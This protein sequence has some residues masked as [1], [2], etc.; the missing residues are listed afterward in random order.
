MVTQSF[1]DYLDTG[2]PDP[3]NASINPRPGRALVDHQGERLVRFSQTM[4]QSAVWHAP[5]IS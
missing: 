4:P 3:V 5:D 2:C 1:R